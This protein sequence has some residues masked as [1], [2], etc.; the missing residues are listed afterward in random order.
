M[1][2][3]AITLLAVTTVLF[4]ATAQVERKH[5]K[6][7]KQQKQHIAAQLNLSDAQKTQVKELHKQNKAKMQELNKQES[8]TVKEYRDKKEA[9]RKAQKEQMQQLLTPEQKTKLVQLKAD[10]Q[11]RKEAK[12]AKKLDKM[13][14]SLQLTDN[15]VARLNADREAFK[16]KIK[17][18]HDNQSLDRV[19]RKEQLTALKTERKAQMNQLLTAEQKEKMKEMHKRKGNR[20]DKA[21]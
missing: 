10:K 15:Q 2:K 6:A 3:I 13:K 14:T 18:I 8:I 16:A 21:K 12:Y 11:A 19:Q 20:Q 4:S 9:L 7:H 5:D 1:K 17:A